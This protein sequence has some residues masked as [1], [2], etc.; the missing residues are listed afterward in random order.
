MK[1][2]PEK[3]ELAFVDKEGS[4]NKEP[5]YQDKED[6]DNQYISFLVVQ[7]QDDDKV[8][9]MVQFG[10]IGLENLLEEYLDMDHTVARW[11]FALSHD[12]VGSVGIAPYYE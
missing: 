3:Q 12:K 7:P 5:G 11:E 9:G 10:S 2:Q 6:F 4:D 1:E 8:V